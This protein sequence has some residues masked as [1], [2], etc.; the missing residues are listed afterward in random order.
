[1]QRLETSEDREAPY[2]AEQLVLARALLAL[3]EPG[4]AETVL[5]PLRESEAE[6]HQVEAWLLT[7]LV[8]DRPGRTIGR[9]SRSDA[10]VGAAAPG[11]IR[12][13]FVMQRERVTR[14]WGAAGSGVG[15]SAGLRPRNCSVHSTR[16]RRP[17]AARGRGAHGAGAG[18][19][20]LPRRR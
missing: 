3:G 14:L 16:V 6:T 12:R 2:A 5:A 15:P 18:R 20:A 8:A 19:A 13:P 11:R 17:D 9:R 4:R 7:A 10:A 1:M